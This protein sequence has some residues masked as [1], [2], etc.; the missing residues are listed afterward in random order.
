ML[1][2]RRASIII[3]HFSRVPRKLGERRRVHALARHVGR[4]QRLFDRAGIKAGQRGG[5]LA[6]RHV[7]VA[8]LVEVLEAQALERLAAQDLI[9]RGLAVGGR[10]K[11]GAADAV[12][13]LRRVAARLMIKFCV[14]LRAGVGV[15]KISAEGSE[16]ACVV[17]K[18]WPLSY[19]VLASRVVIAASAPRRAQGAASDWA[20]PAPKAVDTECSRGR[21][22]ARLLWVINDWL[23]GCERR[24]GG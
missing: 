22:S 13:R 9:P 8:V 16:R 20:P 14:V 17:A 23:V 21:S 4:V 19:S 2:A 7:A 24:E 18:V 12:G 1:A 3:T 11:V 15:V 10:V 6:R 5:E